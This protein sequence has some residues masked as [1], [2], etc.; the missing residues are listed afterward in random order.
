M[1]TLGMM[2]ISAA[3]IIRC[4]SFPSRNSLAHT[5]L[6]QITLRQLEDYVKVLQK[7]LLEF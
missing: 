6:E 7:F 4:D 5:T 1:V 2:H 3:V